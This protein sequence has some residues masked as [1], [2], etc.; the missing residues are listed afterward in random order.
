[1]SVGRMLRIRHSASNSNLFSV[2][3]PVEAAYEESSAY[4]IA[5]CGWQKISPQA[6]P[7]SY[8]CSFQHGK[9][10]IKHI[11]NAM[12]IAQYHKCH[13]WQPAS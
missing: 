10:K 13:Y 1:M 4:D 12:L 5:D 6:I 9:G 11:G 2:K 3:I 8:R 7:Y